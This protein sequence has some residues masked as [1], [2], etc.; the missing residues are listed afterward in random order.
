M[1]DMPDMDMQHGPEGENAT[2]KAKRG[3]DKR[4]SE[5]SH[6][7]AGLLLV[8]AGAFLLGESKLRKRWPWTRYVWPTCFLT[9]GFYLLLFSDTEIWP[10]GHKALWSAL[11]D[12][13]EDR[14]HKIFALILLTI[15][16]VEVQR[17]RGRIQRIWGAWVFP[18]T[19]IL[20]SIMLL[21]H[22]HQA[23]MHGS[24]HRL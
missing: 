6:H 5:L 15:V 4:E 13:A 10:V 8:F 23:G 17:A 20:G 21:F 7:F 14:Q 16:V 3:A 12:S 19:G 1:Q 24:N 11:R 9:A 22:H 18:L 2:Q